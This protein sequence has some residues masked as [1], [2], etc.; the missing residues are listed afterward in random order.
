MC[1]FE[2]ENKKEAAPIT[3]ITVCIK[4]SEK[5]RYKIILLVNAIKM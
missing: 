1:S 5:F 2:K 3:E 4:N